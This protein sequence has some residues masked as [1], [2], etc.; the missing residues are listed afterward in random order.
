MYKKYIFHDMLASMVLEI[1]VLRFTPS[2]IDRL[3]PM[4]FAVG[5]CGLN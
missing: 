2:L 3:R 4:A 1:G 5:L